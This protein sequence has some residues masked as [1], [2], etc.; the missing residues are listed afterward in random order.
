MNSSVADR[1][2]ILILEDNPADARLAFLKLEDAGLEVDGEVACNSAEFMERMRSNV[3]DAI[4]CDY[5]IP[6]WSGRDAL[7]WLRTTDKNTPFIFVSGTLGEE[8][9]VECIK[10]GATD[11]V[12]KGNLER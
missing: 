5:R 11:Y 7:R 3:Y 1:I 9:A 10:E 2:R 8:L 4:L 12:L 6:G